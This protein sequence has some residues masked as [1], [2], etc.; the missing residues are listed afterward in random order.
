MHESSATANLRPIRLL[1]ESVEPADRQ[2]AASLALLAGI[3][4]TARPSM[5]WYQISPPALLLGSSQ[6]PQVA[7]L[8]ACAAAGLPLHRRRSGG[9]VVLCDETLLLFDLALPPD[10]PLY[11]HDVTES[12]RWL[13]EV[14]AAALHQ[15]GLDVRVVPIAE[16]RADSQALD[17]LL[18][19]VCYG[20]LSPY[21]VAAGQ[22]K[23]VG[24]A[25]IRRYNGALL[26]AGVYLRW[27]PERTAAL[28]AATSAERTRLANQL[29]RRVAGLNDLDGQQR[30]PVEL[31]KAAVDAMLRQLAGLAPAA[32]EW[33]ASERTALVE[34]RAP[35]PHIRR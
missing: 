35:Y 25:Q 26:Q 3:E 34:G 1:P 12:Y 9:G 23:L 10:D 6:R 16:A 13:S 22:R 7:D 24:L 2:L 27:S 33:R 29:A 8:E 32:D 19:E 31:V 15:L 18:K 28:M 21:E 14:W 30:L 5:R 20:G 17:P 11:R 4:Q